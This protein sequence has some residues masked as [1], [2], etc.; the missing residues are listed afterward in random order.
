MGACIDFHTYVIG[1]LLVFLSQLPMGDTLRGMLMSKIENLH[2]VQ[3][4]KS[5]HMAVTGSILQLLTPGCVEKAETYR[6]K[7][8]LK[9]FFKVTFLWFSSLCIAV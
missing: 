2:K 3:E 4:L 7:F 6:G 9:E 1:H 8:G 5:I